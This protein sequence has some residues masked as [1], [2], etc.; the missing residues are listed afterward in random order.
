MIF[1]LC[2]CGVD[3]SLYLPSSDGAGRVFTEATEEET[4]DVIEP[5]VKK[6]ITICVDPGHGFED[7]GAGEGNEFLGGVLEKEINLSV[8]NKVKANLEQLGFDV[9]FTHDGESFPTTSIDDGNNRFR[10]EERVAYANSLG[11]TIDYYLSLHCNAYDDPSVHGTVVYYF[12]G[13]SKATVGDADAAAFICDS[14]GKTLPDGKVSTNVFPYYV[15]RYTKVPAS[16]IEMGFLTNKQD[17]ENMLDE[18]WQG[19]L[20]A[21]LAEGIDRFFSG[22]TLTDD[23][24]SNT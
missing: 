2:S 8:A 9:V 6:G 18:E 17:A 19:K 3:K 14:I 13:A 20:A 10:P 5:V 16:L 15:I 4:E 7:G 22:D 23:S 11:D 1:S 12:E 24:D 21:S